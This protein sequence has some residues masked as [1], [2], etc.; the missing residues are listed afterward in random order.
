[1]T[2]AR[3][4][5]S[6]PRSGPSVD[7]VIAGGGP[8]GLVLALELHARGLTALVL[9]PRSGEVDK[10]CGEG[11]MPGALDALARLGVDPP[12]HA[13]RGIQY[14][15]ARGVV[16]HRYRSRE[17]RGVRRTALSACLR[18]K[19]QSSGIEMRTGRV[20][21]WDARPD[22]LV[23]NDV[24]ARWLVGADGLHSRVRAGAGL[25]HAATGMK[26]FG[27]RRHYRISPWSDLVEVTYGPD[28]ELY[29]TPVDADTVGVAVLGGKGVTLD[30]A[31]A[32][33]PPLRD[34]LVGAPVAS[35]LR[36]AGGLRQ[37]TLKRTSGRVALVGDASGYVDAITGEGMRVG[38]AQAEVLAGCLA[39]DDLPAYE[40]EWARSTR[41]FRMLTEGLVRVANSP[42]RSAIVPAARAMPWLFGSVVE[43]L[44]R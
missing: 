42:L 43:R 20:L 7:V 27:M 31:I 16:A 33:H 11:L 19:A 36:G 8:V 21:E 22:S 12:G 9:D 40:R 26:R 39:R 13:I 17:G 38:F 3:V 1:V 28:W 23:V 34:R 18:D 10:A 37:R 44:A 35:E 32:E 25:E 30:R 15:D 14:G 24:R 4:K 29:V 2:T 41:D 5:P 6:A